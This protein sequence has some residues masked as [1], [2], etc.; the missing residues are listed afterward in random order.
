MDKGFRANNRAQ[1]LPGCLI[2]AL[3]VATTAGQTSAQT[4]QPNEKGRVARPLVLNESRYSLRAG[5]PVRIVAP[6]ETIAFIRAAKTRRATV[7]SA[8]RAEIV[9]GPDVSGDGILLAASLTMPPGEYTVDFSATSEAGEVRVTTMAVTLNPM[10]P[11]PSTATQPPVVL[12][13]GWQI[14]LTSSC[15]ISSGSSATFGA[16]Q[17]DLFKASVPVV[18]FFDNCVEDP[19][20]SIEDLGGI[21]WPSSQSNQ[22]RGWNASPSS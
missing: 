1:T 9:V 21:L 2:V 4:V 16:L 20:G 15:P 8:A 5:E 10:L 7:R 17:T 3:L 6:A 19:N 22:V 11:V 14:S 12:L 13:N 18:Y